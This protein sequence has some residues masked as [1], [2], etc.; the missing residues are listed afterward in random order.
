MS[1]T[2]PRGV[3]SSTI[4]K[5]CDEIEDHLDAKM[6]VYYGPS[7][8]TSVECRPDDPEPREAIEHNI[9]DRNGDLDETGGPEDDGG[10]DDGDGLR[11][12]LGYGLPQ[13]INVVA[14][15][16]FPQRSVAPPQA[17]FDSYIFHTIA[18]DES[19]VLPKGFKMESDDSS[20]PPVL[21]MTVSSATE[22]SRLGYIISSSLTLLFLLL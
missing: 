17:D 12:D 8:Q 6:K 21:R 7:T 4:L 19:N 16:F 1:L 3:H 15:T 20:Y 9:F 11:D 2:I 13:A 14:T 18:S 10:D 5:M 22:I